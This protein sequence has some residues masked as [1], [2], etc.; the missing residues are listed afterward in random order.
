MSIR[1]VVGNNIVQATGN[2]SAI[3][4]LKEILSFEVEGVEHSHLFKSGKWDGRYKFLTIDYY[5]GSLLGY[6]GLGLLN[7]VKKNYRGELRIIDKRIYNLKFNYKYLDNLNLRT[8]G[9]VSQLKGIER[10][11]KHKIGIWHCATNFGKSR[12]AIGLLKGISLTNKVPTVIFTHNQIIYKQLC[13]DVIKYC[14][15]KY[16]GRIESG[17][18]KPRLITIGMIPTISRNIKK[19]EYLKYLKTIRAYICDEGHRGSSMTFLKVI[20]KCVSADIRIGMSGTPLYKNQLNNLKLIEQ[21]GEVIYKVKNKT[22]IDKGISAKPT[23]KISSIKNGYEYPLEY[24]KFPKIK[25]RYQ[26]AVKTW[27]VDNQQLNKR[28]VYDIENELKKD[29]SIVIIINRI[30]H[31]KNLETILKNKRIKNL[32]IAGT[33]K[34]NIKTLTKFKK[35]KKQVMIATPV[36]EEGVDIENINCMILA[37]GGKSE[38][39]LLQRIGRSL[40]K[41]ISGKNLVT[42]YDYNIF[43]PLF[44]TNKKDLDGSVVKITRAYLRDQFTE[45]MQYYEREKFKIIKV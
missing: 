24:M 37:G 22:L 4:A 27:I 3:L 39:Q 10:A 15:E 44:I 33:E 8:D 31:A 20:S 43:D 26:Y 36:M 23:I 30:Q 19:L 17:V 9:D 38:R 21:T 41:K 12:M 35:R 14:D 32:Y 16:L 45:R 2:K 11:L 1:L 7:H 5:N 34:D 29:S 6:F 40:R 13:D 28:I 25:Q 18:F 42:V